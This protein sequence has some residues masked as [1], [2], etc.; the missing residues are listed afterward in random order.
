[1]KDVKVRV[2]VEPLD[3][4]GFPPLEEAGHEKTERG[5]GRES[6]DGGVCFSPLKKEQ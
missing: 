2:K 4:L 5:R 1:M 3:L 6:G